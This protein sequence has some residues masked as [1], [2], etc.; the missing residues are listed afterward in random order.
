M[1]IKIPTTYGTLFFLFC[2]FVSWAQQPFGITTSI[3]NTSSITIC[4][5][6][7]VTFIIDQSN[8]ASFDYE[9]IRIR[10]GVTQIVEHNQALTNVFTLPGT[11]NGQYWELEDGDIYYGEIN[12]YDPQPSIRIPTDQITVRVLSSSGSTTID[13][14]VIE[15]ANRFVCS[16]NPGIT[17]TV[18]GTTSGTSF[19]YQWEKSTNGG[20][21]FTEIASATAEF[22]FSGLI[23]QTTFLRR[24]VQANQSSGTCVKY[25]SVF[26][27]TFSDLD[28]GSLN[29]S[30]NQ[31]ICYNTLPGTLGLASIPATVSTGTLSYQWERNTGLGWVDVVNAISATYTPPPLTLTTSFRRKA[32]NATQGRQCETL[33]NSITIIV[34][35]E[36]IGGSLLGSSEICLNNTP[37]PLILNVT[38][39]RTGVN[40]QWQSSPDGNNNN[41]SDLTGVNSL[42]LDFTLL[43]ALTPLS[44]TYYRVKV[45]TVSPTVCEMF[46]SVAS[47]TVYPEMITFT[48]SAQNGV[49]CSGE[50]VTLFASSLNNIEFEYRIDGATVSQ[51]RATSYVLPPLTGTHTLT[52][53]ALSNVLNCREEIDITIV[54]NNVLGGTVEGDQYI[55]YSG[56]GVIPNPIT[57]LTP[58]TVQNGVDI[59]LVASATYQWEFTIN[60][61]LNWNP[62]LNLGNQANYQPGGLFF[63]TSFRR[64]ATNTINGEECFDY[65]NEVTLEVLPDF[66]GGIPTVP[67]HVLCMGDIPPTLTVTNSTQHPDVVYQW[68][69]ST[70]NGMNWTNIIGE[71]QL[72]YTPVSIVSSTLYRVQVY[73]SVSSTTCFAVSD[74][75]AVFVFEVDP[76]NLDISQRRSIGYNTAPGL[77]G[78]GSSGNSA[79]TTLGS[80][81]YSWEQS[82]DGGMNWTAI[83]SSNSEDYT[84]PSFIMDTQFRRVASA[85]NS[86][87]VCSDVSNVISFQISDPLPGGVAVNQEICTGSLP[88]DLELVG[89]SNGTNI[90]YQWEISNDGS[91]YTPISNTTTQLTFTYTTTWNPVSPIT[92]YRVQLTESL[93]GSTFRSG[94]ASITIYDFNLS[95]SSSALTNTFCPG[96]TVSFTATGADSYEFY[97]DGNLVR[98]RSTTSTFSTILM[99]NTTARVLGFSASCSKTIDINLIA[100]S[101][102]GGVIGG[103]VEVC[104]GSTVSLTSIV[105][106]TVMGSSVSS[107]NGSY[108]WQ[109]SSDNMNW[110]DILG[111]QN[112]FYTVSSLIESTYFR[113]NSLNTLNSIYCEDLSNVIN[114][115]VNPFIQ[116]QAGTVLNQTQ[117]DGQVIDPILFS[118]G[119]GATGIS[120]TGLPDGILHSITGNSIIISGVLNVNNTQTQVYAFT[121]TAGGNLCTSTDSISGSITVIAKPQINSSFIQSN[122]VTDVSC[123]GGLDGAIQIPE[124]SPQFDQRI[125]GKLNHVQQQDELKLVYA[126]AL[127][128]VYTIE[129]D[130]IAYEHTVIPVY[131]LGPTQSE[132]QVASALLNEINNATGNRLANVTASLQNSTTL[133]L[134][135]KVPGRSFHRKQFACVD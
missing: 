80:V 19:F 112:S 15:Q 17:L 74:P 33:T 122:D 38:S 67:V 73:S 82:T 23:T 87:T 14:G 121:V 109:R 51:T 26:T 48:T 105:S 94:S 79:S 69:E 133:L 83:P 6:D 54:E 60:N 42:T 106:G 130:G 53:V 20:M 108:Q 125:V 128:D 24:R 84:P 65:S 86:G 63:T 57:T 129:I 123:N 28:P 44:T 3:G 116:K 52:L 98:P 31:S 113:R 45:E 107:G 61:G 66:E 50:I 134:Q 81:T 119:G 64:K 39:S 2:V 16:I 37:V 99:S 114:V 27:N 111:A 72:S 32:I 102:Y 118:H 12:E 131:F 85:T 75:H 70:D 103:P 56:R 29:T 132:S 71:N 92:Y 9:F 93:S 101:V 95:L 55:C 135:A 100:N 4:E 46:S 5:G 97:I 115:Q 7:S 110:I 91:S 68:E 49:Y 1:H 30:L 10:N 124:L 117:C 35:E 58:A 22:Y 41:F 43:P 36:L 47:I 40:Y 126:P 120:V 34:E 96:D 11:Y 59:A 25:S 88:N 8:S 21:S 90:S 104:H 18:S 13:G 62:V 76:G 127:S 78:N 89:A 77:I